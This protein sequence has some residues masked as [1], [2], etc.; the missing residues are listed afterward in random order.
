MK[1]IALL[2]GINVGGNRKVDMKSLKSLFESFGFANVSTYINSGNVVFES[3][4]T[5]EA[6]L[7]KIRTGF[8]KNFDFEMR[9]LVKTAKE[10]KT[11][12]NAVPG[13]WLNDAAQRTDVAYL[14]PEIDSRKTVDELPVDREYIDVRYVKGAVYWNVKREN[15]Y[16]SRLA[17]VIGHE[18]YKS[19]TIRNVNT[20]RRLADD[21]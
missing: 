8:E 10:M 12:A 20:A 18:I 13:D 16:K 7:K 2:R 3:N 14:F 21:T 17:E 5:P 15:V 1:Y 11:I 6:V 4:A 19:M 9:T